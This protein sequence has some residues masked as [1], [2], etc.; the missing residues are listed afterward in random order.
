MGG[1]GQGAHRPAVG[2][3]DIHRVVPAKVNGPPETLEGLTSS[4][5]QPTYMP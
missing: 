4:A 5:K 2:G 1:G 3:A